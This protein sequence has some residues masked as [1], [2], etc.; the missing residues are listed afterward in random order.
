MALVNP[1][2]YHWTPDPDWPSAPFSSGEGYGDPRFPQLRWLE[3]GDG[4]RIPFPRRILSQE[5]YWYCQVCRVLIL[6]EDGIGRQYHGIHYAM[7]VEVSGRRRLSDHAR[8]AAERFM[9]R[10]PQ[11]GPVGQVIMGVFRAAPVARDLRWDQ[12]IR[13]LNDE[14]VVRYAYLPV[15]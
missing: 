9:P 6:V 15:A 11:F 3:A 1:R 4:H 14:V 2:R 8:Q 5:S 7:D 10:T 12:R 13:R